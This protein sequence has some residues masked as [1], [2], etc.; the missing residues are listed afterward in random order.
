MLWMNG[1][2]FTPFAFSQVPKNVIRMLTVKITAKRIATR[3]YCVGSV[4]FWIMIVGMRPAMIAPSVE[5]IM[6]M[7]VNLPRTT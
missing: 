4:L 5:K 2:F 3:K 1:S 6:R 7:P